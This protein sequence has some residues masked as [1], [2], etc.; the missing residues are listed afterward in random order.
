MKKLKTVE[1]E[2]LGTGQSCCSYPRSRISDRQLHRLGLCVVHLG[3]LHGSCPL[4]NTF[5]GLYLGDMSG[6]F[7]KWNSQIKKIFHDD[8]ILQGGEMELKT[9]AKKRW[10]QKKP[11]APVVFG[12][13]RLDIV[14][15]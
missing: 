6:S 10:F 3:S 15:Q 2:M 8:Y 1:L 12:K 7:V 9:W 14:D 11:I 5:N 4:L 13:N